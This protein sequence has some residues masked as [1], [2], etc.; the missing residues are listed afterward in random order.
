VRGTCSAGEAIAAITQGGGVACGQALPLQ[1]TAGPGAAIALTPG[2]SSTVAATRLPGGS[3]FLAFAD[4]QATIAGSSGQGVRV[5]CTI[6]A[7]TTRSTRTHNIRVEVGTGK[8]P[9]AGA[10]PLALAVPAGG[11][12]VAVGCTDSFAPAGSTAPSVTVQSAIDALQ[13]QS[14]S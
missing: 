6:S 14:A 1:V 3:A 11:A 4:P 10:I 9:L 7:S 12:T 2:S 8:E 5:D 13:V